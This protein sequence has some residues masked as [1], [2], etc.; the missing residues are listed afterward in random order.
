MMKKAMIGL[1]V[2]LLVLPAALGVTISGDT[3]THDD[4]PTI[5]CQ[6][7]KGQMNSPHGQHIVMDVWMGKLSFTVETGCIH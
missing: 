5:P 3:S 6:A 2:A 7:V 4:V 1:L